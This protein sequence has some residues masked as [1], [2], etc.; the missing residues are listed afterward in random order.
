MFTKSR[1]ILPSNFK[2]ISFYFIRFWEMWL[3]NYPLTFTLYFPT[4]NLMSWHG[5]N[6]FLSFYVSRTFFSNFSSIWW[7]NPK[8]LARQV[9]FRIWALMVVREND[10]EL[11]LMIQFDFLVTLELP[12]AYLLVCKPLISTLWASFSPFLIWRVW[13][14]LRSENILSFLW[15]KR[16]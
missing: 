15:E 9:G 3:F 7:G 1:T 13:E 2:S 8:L 5:T 10:L 16:I 11:I 14:N 6:G 12:S 4:I